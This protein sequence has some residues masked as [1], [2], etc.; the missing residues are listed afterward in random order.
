MEVVIPKTVMDLVTEARAQI[1]NIS[2]VDTS[3]EMASGKAVLVDVRE[4][5]EWEHHIQGAFQIPRGL[6][7]FVADPKC[8]SRLPP[9]LKFDMDPSRRV[10]VYCNTGGRGVPFFRLSKSMLDDRKRPK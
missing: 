1:E 10:I 5:L 3:E 6:L 4:L 7:E 2:P 8:E 9:S